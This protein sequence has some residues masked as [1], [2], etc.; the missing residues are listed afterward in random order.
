MKYC[1]NCGKQ[2][3]D[4]AKFCHNCGSQIDT[5]DNGEK[6]QTEYEG[7]IHKCPNCGQ[8]VDAFQD[9]CPACGYKFRD[10]KANSS[11][12]E[13]AN[14]LEQVANEKNERKFWRKASSEVTYE[15]VQKQVQIIQNFPIPNTY[16]D[17]WEFLILSSSNI[18]NDVNQSHEQTELSNAWK[19]KFDQAYNKARL[20][21]D[22]PKDVEK[23]ERLYTSKS[24]EIQANKKHN[25]IHRNGP[26]ISLFVLSV[27]SMSASLF[28]VHNEN[29]EIQ[30]ENE[31]LNA[32]VAEVYDCIDSENY[33]LARVKA[34]SLTFK[35]ASSTTSDD[36]DL[37]KEWDKTRENLIKIIDEANKDDNRKG[38]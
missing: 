26:I 2:L 36:D 33:T 28:M 25:F 32:I 14:K 15:K 16:E 9:D 24:R 31:R 18:T 4:D 8:A 1:S 19:S 37:R 10:V 23:L 5:S 29:N 21:M 34:A 12:K 17:L 6:R 22:N 20:V 35:Y 13:L 27:I 38:E 30:R 11:V 7:K 3:C